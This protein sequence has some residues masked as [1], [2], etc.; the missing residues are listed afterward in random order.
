MTGCHTGHNREHDHDHGGHDHN[1]GDGHIHNTSTD[2]EGGHT[3][4]IIFSHEQAEAIGLQIET[5]QP[6]TFHQVIKTS[7]EIQ[8]QTADEVTIAATADGIITFARSSFIEGTPIGP[9]ETVVTISSRNL[10]EGERTSRIR[11]DYEN[12][13]SEYERAKNLI[14]DKI[15]STREYEQIRSR[16]ETARIA[17]EAQAGSV[18]DK[19]IVVK[20]PIGGF[21]KN[22]MVEQGAYV[23]VGQPIA[24]I[25]RNRSLQ[26]RA[27]VSE[28][29]YPVLKNIQTA[30][31][32]TAYSNTLYKLE[33]LNGRLLSYGKTAGNQS[34]YIPITF[35]FDNVG[36]ILPGAFTEIWLIGAAQ[37]DKLTL[38]V[39]ALSEEQGLYFVYR[40][41]GEEEY[42]KQEITIGMNDGE[43]VEILSGITT[44]DKVVIQGVTQ[45]KLAANA[46]LI[47][48][49]HTH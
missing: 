36:D 35:E 41:I 20:A 6:R 15:I 47:P 17:Y 45:I 14:E 48:E 43:R 31:F 33:N 5:V 22:R 37:P 10:P 4:E 23:T 1:H 34:Y 18:S 2:K 11:V 19:G 16:Y 38:P 46:G 27:E 26:L 32:R 24:T 40:Q 44:G 12:A 21:V 13:R 8:N 3:D 7:G 25:T 28:K 30:H 49:G 29:Y 42:Q 39:S 9:G